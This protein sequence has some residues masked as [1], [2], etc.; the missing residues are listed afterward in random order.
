MLR[1]W[2]EAVPRARGSRWVTEKDSVSGYVPS[3]EARQGCSH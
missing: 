2:L 1:M 3:A